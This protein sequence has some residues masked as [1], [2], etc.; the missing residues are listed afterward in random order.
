M[1][2]VGYV[3]GWTWLIREQLESGTLVAKHSHWMQSEGRFY[4]MRPA[5]RHQRRVVREVSD[6]LIANNVSNDT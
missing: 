1:Q 4:L 3:L 6:W 5:D 2:G